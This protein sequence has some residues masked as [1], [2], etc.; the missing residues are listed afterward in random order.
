VDLTNV[1]GISALTA[2]TILREIGTDVSRFR[3]ASAFASWL[4]LCP[5]KKISGGKVLFT[6]S[7]RVRS[8]V[9]TAL[10]MSAQ[11][12]HHAKDYLG[13]FFRRITRKLGRP[14]AITATAHKLAR[15]VF[16]LLSTKEAYTE[17]VFHKS[18]EETIRRAQYRLRRQAAQLGFLVIPA[19]NG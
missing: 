10:R 11:S 3:N 19:E 15:I 2:Q 1:P 5:E 14:Q 16:H 13:E 9:A 6:K 18:E 4:G 7:R 8:R 12:L 17:S